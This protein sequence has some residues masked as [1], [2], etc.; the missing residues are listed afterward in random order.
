MS[1]IADKMSLVQEGVREL[2]ESMGDLINT[3]GIAFK[4]FLLCSRLGWEV[5][6]S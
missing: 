6:P 3:I 4:R 5:F 1:L 2:I